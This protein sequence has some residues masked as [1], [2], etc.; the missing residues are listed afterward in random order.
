MQYIKP[1]QLWLILILILI[2]DGLFMYGFFNV[3]TEFAGTWSPFMFAM[4]FVFSGLA[5][6]ILT[7]LLKD[8]LKKYGCCSKEIKVSR[9]FNANNHDEYIDIDY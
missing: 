9:V 4:C 7:N 1:K 3:N 5:I 8:H 6:L 2:I